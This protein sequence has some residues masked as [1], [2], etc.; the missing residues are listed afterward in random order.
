MKICVILIFVAFFGVMQCAADEE[1][2][3]IPGEKLKIFRRQ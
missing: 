1:Q 2:G 3:E